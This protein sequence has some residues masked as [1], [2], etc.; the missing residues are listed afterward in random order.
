VEKRISEA[1]FLSKSSIMKICRRKNSKNKFEEI[2]KNG[3]SGRFMKKILGLILVVS[4]HFALYTLHCLYA[5]S[6]KI[7]GTRPLALGGA[8]VAVG[9]DAITQYWNPASLGVGRDVNVQIPVNVRLEATGDILGSAN[10]LAK[11]ADQFSQISEAQKA[12][13]AIDLSQLKTFFNSIKTLDELNEGGKGIMADVSAGGNVRVGHYA[14]SINNFTSFGCDPEIDIKNI[15][16]GKSSDEQLIGIDMSKLAG[17][18]TSTP[19]DPVLQ[20]AANNLADNALGDL[21]NAAE[22][23]GIEL[24]VYSSQEIANAL[25]NS[26]TN[27]GLSSTQIQD[28]VS[29]INKYE[30]KYVDPILDVGTA[31]SYKNN[32]SNLTVRGASVFEASLGYGRK[33]PYVQ[34]TAVLGGF[35]KGLHIGGNL[36]YMKGYVGYAKAKVLSDTDVDPFSDLTDNWVN[37]NAMGIDL[38]LLI[39]KKLFRKKI[40]GGLLLRNI[41]SPSFAQPAE[42]VYDGEPSKY[43]LSPQIRGGV[44]VWPF[45]WW[46]VSM[47]IDLTKN[48]TPLPGYFSRLWG[49]GNEFNLVNS[50]WF[51][52][53]LRCGLM[54]NLAESSSRI[55]YTSGFGFTLAH[56]VIDFGGA[57]ST[58]MVEVTGGT[59]VPAS[60]AAALTISFDF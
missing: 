18:D 47:D 48:S 13:K 15:G 36:K 12:G 43:K 37:S 42:A 49:L 23:V 50:K 24:G 6:F 29:T 41:N 16:L 8:Y 60:G 3:I 27:Q 46:T 9:E 4:L 1:S 44:A 56:L 31:T 45:N 33:C 7:L 21:E 32:K 52:L 51:N 26:A 54:K 14:F 38:G 58:D 35:L 5:D 10:R 17:L 19:S 20:Q 28:A 55:A 30:D 22:N 39:K 53:A 34:S 2:L 11:I 40:R 57:M 59:E 25:I